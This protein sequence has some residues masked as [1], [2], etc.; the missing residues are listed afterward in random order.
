MADAELGD[1]Q[2]GEDP[3]TRRLEETVA[4][5][6]GMDSAMYMPTGSMCNKVAVSALTKPGDALVCDHLAHVYRFEGGGSAVLSGIVFEPLATEK[7]IFTP[8][9][10]DAVM[11]PGSVYEPRTSLVSIEQTHN[12]GGGVVWSLEEYEAVCAMARQHGASIFTDGARLLN[13]VAASGVPADRWA[14]P[15]DAVWIDF[16]KGVGAPGGAAIAGSNEFIATAK[17]FKYLYGG[18]LRQSGVLAAAALYGI[19]HNVPRM[20]DDHDHARILAAGLEETGLD[21]AAPESN[22]VFCDPPSD[23]ELQEF[24]AAM[25]SEGVRIGAVAGRIRMVTHVNVSTE[26][27]RTAIQAARRVVGG[28]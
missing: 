23:M 10:L 16:S 8:E 18:A 19:E 25:G 14:A 20:S 21:V 15:V 9:Q 24:I 28:S 12:F 11:K 6:M 27:I 17:R 5:M 4:A 2:M 22:M 7:G 13:A 26:D 3:T 1:E